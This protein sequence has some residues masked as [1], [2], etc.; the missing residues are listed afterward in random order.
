MNT[1]H[2]KTRSI[3]DNRALAGVFAGGILAAGCVTDPELDDLGT[4]ESATNVACI[5]TKTLT[6]QASIDALAGCTSLDD[7]TIDDVTL[8][9]RTADIVSLRALGSV[10]TITRLNI[11]DAP[12]LTSLVGLAAVTSISSLTISHTGVV[13]VAALASLGNVHDI[14]ISYNPSL[15]SLSGFSSLN[16]AGAL[17]I[18][19]NDSLIDLTGL[20]RIQTTGGMLAIRYNDRLRSLRG[21]D[22]LTTLGGALYVESNNALATLAGLERLQAVAGV[23]L[24]IYGNPALTTTD[25]MR[26]FTTAGTV[27]NPWIGGTIQIQNNA[28]LRDIVGIHQVTRVS[29]HLKVL[30]NALLPEFDGFRPTWNGVS[31]T[32]VPSG[33]ALREVDGDIEISNNSSLTKPQLASLQFVR[34]SVIISDNPMLTEI[35]WPSAAGI[36][37]PLTAGSPSGTVTFARNAKLSTISMQTMAFDSIGVD[38][39]ATSQE[40]FI[41]DNPLL[42]PGSA[43]AFANQVEESSAGFSGN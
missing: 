12:A 19:D 11:V 18:L 38:N 13:S 25:S 17:S 1:T 33:M 24:Y 23:G 26:S 42:G 35:T 10:R 31:W 14:E 41:Q 4:Q 30:D 34:H 6:T 32:Q 5:G 36:G 29:G 8:N 39:S 9:D 37:A 40:L 22:N 3:R 27:L 28:S 20:E 2:S 16:L 21:L 7:V 43:A 15:A